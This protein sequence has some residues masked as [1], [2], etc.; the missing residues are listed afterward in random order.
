MN[1]LEAE[2]SLK[3]NQEKSLTI[4]DGIIRELK[5][6]RFS[7]QANIKELL[8]ASNA[9]FDR[10]LKLKSYIDYT[11]SSTQLDGTMLIEILNKITTSI[12][13]MEFYQDIYQEI[14][15]YY[16]NSS[17]QEIDEESI[18]PMM[19]LI[20]E[21]LLKSEKDLARIKLELLEVK[22]KINLRENYE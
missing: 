13:K 18:K 2:V 11:Y 10:Q 20:S 19:G 6:G 5:S 12:E 14:T 16:Q 8:D 7:S 15:S 22:L 3:I 1:L 21:F 17:S 4:K 9:L